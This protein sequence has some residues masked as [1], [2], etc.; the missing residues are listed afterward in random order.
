MDFQQA[1]GLTIVFLVIGLLIGLAIAAVI[2]RAA[3]ALFNKMAGGA[4]SPGSV[5]SPGF[6]KA[7]LMVLV[8][9]IIQVVAGIVLG[10]MG[11]TANMTPIMANLISTPISFLV[12]AGMISAL[13][14][15]S[16]G[17]G[18]GVALC[19]FII[20]ILILVAVV[21]IFLVI[22]AAMFAG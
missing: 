4:G 1:A 18:L 10:V 11:V 5:P 3:C 21:V 16:F 8:I 20:M 12:S 9:G 19:Q 15:T 22:G 6:G 17:K 2:L 7:M 14:P 13:L